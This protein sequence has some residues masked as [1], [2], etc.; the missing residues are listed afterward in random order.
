MK[1]LRLCFFPALLGV[2]AIGVV[3]V[4]T[5]RTR[6]VSS[7]Q[8]VL[9]SDASSQVLLEFMRRLD[10]SV[11]YSN[12]P[13]PESNLK[14][15]SDAVLAASDQ[16]K[17]QHDSLSQ[18]ELHESEYYR[19]KHLGVAFLHGRRGDIDSF[20]SS[21]KQ[22]LSSSETISGPELQ[23]IQGALVVL[24][25]TRKQESLA[26]FVGWLRGQNQLTS[27]FAPSLRNQLEGISKRLELIGSELTLQSTTLQSEAFDLDQWKGRV[28]LIEFWGTRCVPCVAELP[29]L[30]R[31]HKTYRERGFEIIGICL[32]AEPERI[33][34]F[35]EEHDLPWVQLCH[36]ATASS[37]CND[38]LSD[39]FGIQSIPTTMLLD[40][41]GKVIK[42]GVRPLAGDLEYDLETVLAKLL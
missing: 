35:V 42:F 31:I 3:I 32:N 39:R 17:Q 9:P 28:V 24:E 1:Y 19:L 36:Q 20:V 14:Q 34:R 23:I 16:L 5:F 6:S 7:Q 29:A 26:E 41:D 15:V 33:R 37:A 21:T 8:Y 13:I 25:S 12:L 18:G 10:G 38:I 2:V 4:D 27:E 40:A 11:E 22:Y 30:K